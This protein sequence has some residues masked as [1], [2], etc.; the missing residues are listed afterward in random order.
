MAG[1]VTVD[2][3]LVSGVHLGHAVVR[4]KPALNKR[5]RRISPSILLSAF[6]YI[7]LI[8]PLHRPKICRRRR[9]V[10]AVLRSLYTLLGTS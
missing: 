9:L 6:S 7:H 1:L 4:R 2:V 3:A 10:E 8:V 5:R